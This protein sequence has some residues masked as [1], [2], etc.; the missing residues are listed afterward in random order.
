MC[1]A[2]FLQI[3]LQGEVR[4]FF[5]IFVVLSEKFRHSGTFLKSAVKQSRISVQKFTVVILPIQTS[6]SRCFY[7]IIYCRVL[8]TEGH[9]RKRLQVLALK[10]M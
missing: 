1:I 2:F 10:F 6:Y 8:Q 3:C 4:K 7:E 9:F 5:P